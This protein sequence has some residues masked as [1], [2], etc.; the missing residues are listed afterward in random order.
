MHYKFFTVTLA[1]R[2]NRIITNYIHLDQGGFMPRCDLTDNRLNILK[3]FNRRK[4]E[5]IVLSLDLEKAF[6]SV[7]KR[8]INILLRCLNFGPSFQRAI[9]AMYKNPQADLNINN[10]TT[11]NF[12]L[13][14]GTRQGCPLSPIPF[15]IALE[16]LLIKMLLKFN[17]R[18]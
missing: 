17:S 13:D 14:K 10:S 7:E 9:E 6:D 8:C 5:L 3:Y 16:P 1:K 4:I 11:S 18:N 12:T 15:A 2:L